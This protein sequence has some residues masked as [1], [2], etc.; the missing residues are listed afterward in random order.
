MNCKVTESKDTLS[1]ELI[2]QILKK[3]TIYKKENEDK[4][5]STTS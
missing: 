4:E 2:K 5:E 1:T 3:A